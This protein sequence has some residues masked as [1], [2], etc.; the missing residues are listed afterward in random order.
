MCLHHS[1]R[2]QACLLHGL[3]GRRAI[4]TRSS[5]R[6][7]GNQLP[8]ENRTRCPLSDAPCLSPMKALLA[9][10][11]FLNS[12]ETECNKHSPL[13]LKKKH[14]RKQHFRLQPAPESHD[15]ELPKLLNKSEC[16]RRER[17]KS[18]GTIRN[19]V[20]TCASIP[21]EGAVAG[22]NGKSPAGLPDPEAATC[23]R[24]SRH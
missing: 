22:Q 24:I 2:F 4:R 9:L 14:L 20:V 18:P 8:D 12:F 17:L 21:E 10:A 1:P 6:E 11:E 23:S 5:L 19:C 16:K 13:R 7:G 15:T 3:L